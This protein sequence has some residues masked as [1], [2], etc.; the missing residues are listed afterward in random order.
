MADLPHLHG[1]DPNEIE[2]RLRRRYLDRLALR[3]RKMRRQLLDRNW[4]A[5]RVE[6]EHLEGTGKVFGLN[7]I[8]EFAEN[9]KREIP[10]GHVS[11]LLTL[12]SARNAVE[13]LIMTIEIVLSDKG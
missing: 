11:S 7:T 13:H 3:V 1:N 2:A 4:D 12:P 8:A 10:S 9:A 6:C 5:L